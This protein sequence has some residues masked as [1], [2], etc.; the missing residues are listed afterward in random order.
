MFV[1]K[2]TFKCVE[3]RVSI[4]N[5]KNQYQWSFIVLIF[6]IEKK[7]DYNW[8]AFLYYASIK[9]LLVD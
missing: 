4:T 7:V 9:P 3:N 5:I 2:N 1:T 8:L 6:K